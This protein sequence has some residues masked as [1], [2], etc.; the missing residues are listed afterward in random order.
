MSRIVSMVV[1]LDNGKYRAIDLSKV[2][3]I[4][5]DPNYR[6]PA[7]TGDEGEPAGPEMDSPD[8]SPTASAPEATRSTLAAA[9]N[10]GGDDPP[11]PPP[12]PN[13]YWINGAWICL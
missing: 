2:R 10:G 7:G 12:G 3:S 6:Q 8:F 13:C 9:E 4:H 11:G 5:I 1:K